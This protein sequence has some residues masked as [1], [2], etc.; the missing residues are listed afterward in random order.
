MLYKKTQ[1]EKYIKIGI[2]LFVLIL[3]FIL[4]DK[5]TSNAKNER[6]MFEKHIRI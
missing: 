2:F 3:N 4:L 6:I 1:T 5:V